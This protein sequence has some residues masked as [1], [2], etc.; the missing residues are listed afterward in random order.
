M[1]SADQIAASLSSMVVATELEDG[2]RISTHCLYPSNGAVSV[3]VRGGT[4]E[5]VV[6]D[7]RGALRE[8]S[9]AG[10]TLA[11]ADRV[12][13]RLVKHRGLAVQ[14]GEIYSPVIPV[15][16]IPAGIVLVANAAKEVA[17]WGVDHLSVSR[18]RNFRKDLQVLLAQHFNDQMKNDEHVVG[19]SSKSHKFTHVIYLS[20]GRKL[21]VDPAVNEPSSINA[22]VVANLDVRSMGNPLIDQLIVYDDRLNWSSADLKLLEVGATTVPFSRAER[23][24]VRRAA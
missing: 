14:R 13:Q 24:I 19:A 17:E 8:L 11:T 12:L 9:G 16:A 3:V 21:L 2:V 10:L 23:E 5:F 7:D 18:P 15:H 6:S 1:M 22:R 4:N 20:G